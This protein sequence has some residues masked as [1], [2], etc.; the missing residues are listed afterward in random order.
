MGVQPSVIGFGESKWG[1]LKER[2]Q[3]GFWDRWH[4][5]QVPNLTCG[6][7]CAVRGHFCYPS[8]PGFS[9]P[10]KSS[11]AAGGCP[12]RWLRV[13]APPAAGRHMWQDLSCCLYSSLHCYLPTL[14]PAQAPQALPPKIPSHL[15][16]AA[17]GWDVHGQLL[18]N[19][20]ARPE[21][22]DHHRTYRS[23]Q[24]TYIIRAHRSW[25]HREIMPAHRN[26]K[27]TNRSCSEHKWCL[28]TQIVT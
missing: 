3:A 22:T 20:E 4:V 11:P 21:H 18:S 16:D 23:C 6:L 17:E 27:S 2:L 12:C 9:W 5:R 7:T 1:K 14:P 13:A 26:H 15:C 28:H 19:Q 8:A 25:E 10:Q 24:H